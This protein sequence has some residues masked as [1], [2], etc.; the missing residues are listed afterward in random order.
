MTTYD[1]CVAGKL[2]CIP[3]RYW[4]H[5]LFPGFLDCVNVLSIEHE[6]PVSYVAHIVLGGYQDEILAYPALLPGGRNKK[7]AILL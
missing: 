4:H 3:W 1:F 6:A 7:M 2:L 5:L